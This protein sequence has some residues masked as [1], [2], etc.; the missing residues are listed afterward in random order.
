MYQKYLLTGA[1]GFL[2]RAVVEALIGENVKIRALVMREDPLAATLPPGID[3]ICGDVC[4]NRSLRSFFSD[5]DRQTCVIHMAGI[6]SVASDPG[7]Q[8]Y[9]VNVNGTSN[10]LTQCEQR[11]VG[12]LIYVS[13]V[14]AIPEK[15]KGT[16]IT[17]EAFYSPKLVEGDYAKSKAMAT[18]LVL[19]AARFGLNTNVVFPSG[20]IG[21]G[22]SGK[23]SI[24]HMLSAFLAGRL[25][26]AV[27]G[28]YDFVDVRDV[29]SGIVACARYGSPGKGYILSGHYASVREILEAAGRAAGRKRRVLC[30]PMCLAK[31]VAPLYEKWSVWK[32]RPLFF[33]PYA[34]SVLDSNG[35]FD[36]T[37]AAQ[38]LGYEPRSLQSS[39]D[40]MVLW[41]RE[42][43]LP[44]THFLRN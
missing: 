22:D 33:T 11:R 6:V 32:H 28:G 41:I 42:A 29:A 7:M 40:D 18:S 43:L 13:S 20:I 3:T 16:A 8:L 17:E 31:A 26:V 34:V 37:A 2:G 9:R 10:I 39:I 1:T 30:L 44:P 36:R 14:H 23:G 12:K 5:A 35:H 19:H 24:T 25:P 38:A 27:Q 4:D 15:P 21:P